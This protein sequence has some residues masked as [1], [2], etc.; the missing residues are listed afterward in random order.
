MNSTMLTELTG[1]IA[2]TLTTLA[3]LPQAYKI[4]KTHDT[5]A[6]SLLMFMMM[7]V[8]V[9]MWL[10]YGLQLNQAPIIWANAVTLALAGYI[11]VIK[12]TNVLKNKEPF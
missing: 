4:F 7:N 3:Y 11:L 2:A 8:G 10:M 5:K 12:L 9:F 1:D 6:I